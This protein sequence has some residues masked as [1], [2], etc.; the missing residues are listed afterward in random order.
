LAD[1]T[2]D[3]WSIDSPAVDAVQTAFKEW[4]VIVEA[5]GSGEQI[6]ILR[7]GGIA[8]GAG[9]FRAEHNRFWLF[10]TCFHHQSEGMIKSARG[11]FGK[12][13]WP[14]EDILKIEFGAEVIEARQ[15]GLLDQ[16]KRLTGQHIWS[17][18][19]ITDRF[20]RGQEQGVYAMIVRVLRLP[21]PMEM[22]ML[23]SYGGC[24]SWV[25]LETP[26][27]FSLAEPVLDDS[28]FAV[29]LTAF[30]EALA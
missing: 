11:R 16:A 12:L 13:Q 17:E 10:P 24:K 9:G 5:L 2:F 28:D 19:V 20:S 4:A 22:P 23:E 1:W 18:Q 14:A 30:Q 6:L 7:K 27:D 29:K 26:I 3:R 25:E 15:L 8:E 21:E